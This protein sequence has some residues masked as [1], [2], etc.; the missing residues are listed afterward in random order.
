[1]AAYVRGARRAGAR[2]TVTAVALLCPLAC[3]PVTRPTVSAAASSPAFASRPVLFAPRAISQPSPIGACLQGQSVDGP[4]EPSLAVDPSDPRHLVAAWQEDRL[5]AGGALRAAVAVSRDGGSN[6]TET[7]LPAL[8]TC[9]GGPYGR[10]TDT[11]ASVGSDGT[12]YVGALAYTGS[13]RQAIVISVARTDGGWSSPFSVSVT[14]DPGVPFDKPAILADPRRAGR[15]YA[16]WAKYRNQASII[17]DEVVFARSDDHGSTWSPPATIYAAGTEAQNNEIFALQ[18]G[19]LADVFAEGSP[20][21]TLGPGGAPSPE[22]LR[23][24][25]STDGGATWSSPSTVASFMYTVTTDPDQGT[26]IRSTGQDVAAAAGASG[27]YVT[28]FESHRPGVSTIWVARSTDGGRSWGPASVLVQEPEQAFLPTIA[29]DGRGAVGAIWY[30]LRHAAAG[31]GL[32]TEVWSGIS[33]DRGATWRSG[34]LGEPFDLRAAPSTYLGRFIGDYEGLV[35]LRSGFA[36]AY[37]TVPAPGPA[38]PRTQIVF[39]T[40]A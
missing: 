17:K 13:T 5:P 29:T 38:A 15:V 16:V 18:D 31:P 25:R 1:M 6:W 19:S 36:A 39:A 22:R 20:S 8:T 21:L 12:A 26:D 3:T 7:M 27:L 10:I 37:V 30:D 35:G 23:T 24:I 34:R 40:F 32:G 9:T 14:T 11:W 33:A 4:E 28:W 2:A